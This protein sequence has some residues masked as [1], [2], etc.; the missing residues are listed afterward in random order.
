MVHDTNTRIISRIKKAPRN[1]F[2]K[3]SKG[4]GTESNYLFN[5]LKSL[6][7]ENTH[8]VIEN[9]IIAIPEIMRIIQAVI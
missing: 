8:S 1:I 5:F 9:Q 3:S 7:I 4:E 2:L 6:T